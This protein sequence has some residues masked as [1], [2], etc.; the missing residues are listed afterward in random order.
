M[1]S[2][3]SRNI[4]PECCVFQCP[5]EE[6]WRPA[7]HQEVGGDQACHQNV[8]FFSVIFLKVLIF[9]FIKFEKI[10][11]LRNGPKLRKRKIMVFDP[12]NPPNLIYGHLIYL[13]F[14]IVLGY[15]SCKIN[16]HQGKNTGKLV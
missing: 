11:F 10:K 12:V 8:D 3:N 16:F 2:A 6:G 1:N 7:Q 5:G 4:H 9:L 13:N 15:L 14:S